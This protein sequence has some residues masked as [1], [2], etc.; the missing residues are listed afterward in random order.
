MDFMLGVCE[1]NQIFSQERNWHK[2]DWSASFSQKLSNLKKTWKMNLTKIPIFPNCKVPNAFFLYLFTYSWFLNFLC[3]FLSQ[4]KILEDF[5]HLIIVNCFFIFFLFD[6]H[7]IEFEEFMKVNFCIPIW[8]TLLDPPFQDFIC[9]VSTKELKTLKIKKDIVKIN[10]L[11][12]I[13]HH[14]EKTDHLAHVFKD[15]GRCLLDS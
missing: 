9:S 15:P 8:I 13:W 2:K 4:E 11:I 7:C 12:A 10:K 6:Q 1:K 3:H 5:L 14:F